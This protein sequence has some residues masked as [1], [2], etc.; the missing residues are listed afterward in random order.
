MKRR[1]LATLL[2]G[3]MMAAA[4]GSPVATLPDPTLDEATNAVQALLR[5]SMAGGYSM[6]I[7][8]GQPTQCQK[9]MM[10]EVEVRSC[11][12]CAEIIYVENQGFAVFNARIRREIFDVAFKRGQSFAQP[13]ISPT[14]AGEGVW[15]PVIPAA[16]NQY[17]PPQI[18]REVQETVEIN[19]ARAADLTGHT[20]RRGSFGSSTFYGPN[21]YTESK[22]VY[23][24]LLNIPSAARNSLVAP[25]PVVQTTNVTVTRNS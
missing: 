8:S 1:S 9:G 17:S 4:C 6:H 24:A 22:N 12:V 20:Y 10:G 25:C 15:V 19:P 23:Q 18:S 13:D 5:A 21:G 11:K 7:P 2:T 3:S 16:V 14:E